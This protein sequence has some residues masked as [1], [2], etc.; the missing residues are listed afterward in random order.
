MIIFLEECVN[1][2]CSNI[3]FAIISSFELDALLRVVCPFF[4]SLEFLFAI[5][6]NLGNYYELAVEIV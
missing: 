3:M 5:G 1:N 6:N 2:L 4:F